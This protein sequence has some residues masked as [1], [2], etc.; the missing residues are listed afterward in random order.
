MVYA[1][2]SRSGT[3]IARE[4]GSIG[5]MLPQPPEDIREIFVQTRSPPSSMS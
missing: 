5:G 1:S 2:P 3:G 4:R